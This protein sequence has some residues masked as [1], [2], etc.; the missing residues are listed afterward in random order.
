MA[1]VVRRQAAQQGA[2]AAA[3]RQ[4]P[5][6]C[7]APSQTA[8]PQRSPA[9][10]PHLEKQLRPH[11][12]LSLQLASSLP[13]APPQR[14]AGRRT[15]GG[16]LH[17]QTTAS[18]SKEQLQAARAAAPPDSFLH[19]CCSRDEHHQRIH[20]LLSPGTLPQPVRAGFESQLQNEKRRERR[21][22]WHDL[23]SLPLDAGPPPRRPPRAYDHWRAAATPGSPARVAR[24]RGSQPCG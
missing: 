10:W 2:E 9:A 5:R 6:H 4:I 17:S 14:N 15:E 1:G 8:Q 16:C 11:L 20:E 7:G 13:A 23:S 12:S 19:G 18:G 22:R 21:P 24:P 3:P